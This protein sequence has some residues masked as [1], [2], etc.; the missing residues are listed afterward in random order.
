MPASLPLGV[1]WRNL[2]TAL[3][4]GELVHSHQRPWEPLSPHLCQHSPFV[5]LKIPF[6]PLTLKVAIAFSF[7]S[8]DVCWCKLAF[9]RWQVV[10]NSISTAKRLET[11]CAWFYHSQLHIKDTAPLRSEAGETEA[12]RHGVTLKWHRW[13][14][15]ASTW[16]GMLAELSLCW[17]LNVAEVA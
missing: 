2:H 10:T 16:T 4:S 5:F 11:P 17:C 1:P 6:S 13:H 15:E 8:F 7:C 14:S 12:R 3:S 9:L